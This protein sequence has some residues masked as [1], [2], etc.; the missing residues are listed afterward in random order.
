MPRQGSKGRGSF[1]IVV[2]RTQHYRPPITVRDN[3]V[4]NKFTRT[5]M[6]T[7]TSGIIRT[8]GD[9]T[10]HGFFIVTKYSKQVGDHDCCARFTRGLPTSAMVLATKYTGCQCG[11]LPLKSVGNVPHMLSTKR[12]GSD[13]SLTVVT[14]GLRRIFKL[15]SV[16][17]LP[18]MCGVT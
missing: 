14:V 12:Y 17:S 7:L 9:N 2:R 6:V 8:M 15:G 18:V 5:R 13:C 10:V 4:M 3:G 16:G 11:G 1:S